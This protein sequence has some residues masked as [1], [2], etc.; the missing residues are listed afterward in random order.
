MIALS[1]FNLERVGHHGA[2][3][4]ERRGAIVHI[5]VDGA[6]D[7]YRLHLGAKRLGERRADDAFNALFKPVKNSHGAPPRGLSRVRLPS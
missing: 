1:E 4:R 2:A 5:A 3:T 6:R 7:L